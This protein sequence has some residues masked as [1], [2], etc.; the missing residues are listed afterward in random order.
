MQL[1]MAEQQSDFVM[2]F[3]CGSKISDRPEFVHMTPGVQMQEG[4]TSGCVCVY[5][6]GW[7]VGFP[8][9]V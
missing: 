2:G 4:G 5:V 1:Q 8:R 9:N 7:L 6:C 3:I